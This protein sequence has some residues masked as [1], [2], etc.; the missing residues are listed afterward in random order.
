VTIFLDTNI[1]LYSVSNRPEEQAKRE[2]AAAI[3]DAEDCAL[4]IQVLLEFYH[5][6]TRPTRVGSLS[7]ELADGFVR[8]WIRFPIQ[9]NTT[10][11][12]V[13]GIDLS[14]SARLSIWDALIVAAAQEAGCDTLMTEDLSHGQRFG[15]LRVENPF[16]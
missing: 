2:I 8:S 13:A 15:A 10:A 14:R 7:A 12:L 5:Q 3:I 11:L 1:L 16:R 4:S 6:A 9:Q